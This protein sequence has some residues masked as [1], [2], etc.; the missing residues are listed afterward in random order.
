MERDIRQLDIRG[1]GIE[2]RGGDKGN[3]NNSW[4]IQK[5]YCKREI[6]ITQILNPERCISKA[7]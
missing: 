5:S 3:I 4:G 6:F 2:N 1:K 7:Y